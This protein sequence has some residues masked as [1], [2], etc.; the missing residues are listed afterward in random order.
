MSA[1]LPSVVLHLLIACSPDWSV[2]VSEGRTGKSIVELS[3][4]GEVRRIPLSW[5]VW[6]VQRGDVDGDGCPDLLLGVLKRNRFDSTERRRLQ[7]WK[8]DR[9]RMRPGWLGTRLSGDLD[10]FA[11]DGPGRILARERIGPTWQLAR[12]RWKGFGFRMD[13]ILARDKKR[14]PF[15]ATPSRNP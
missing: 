3:S 4:R 14:P 6:T 5:P 10:T 1:L 11:H 7:F 12:W 13:S 15:P 2:E 8:I 9:G